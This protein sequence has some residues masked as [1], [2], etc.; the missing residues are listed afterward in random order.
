MSGIA[1]CVVQWAIVGIDPVAA[2]PA[3]V[4]GPA[5]T[6]VPGRCT[7]YEPSLKANA[8]PGGWDVALMSTYIW[9]ESKCDPT[10]RSPT[11]DTGL[12]QINDIN[13][14]YLRAALG[15]WV[16]RWS[17]TEPDVNIRSAATLCTFWQARGQSC[18]F[19]WKLDTKSPPTN[20]VSPTA[21]SPPAASPALSSRAPTSAP[22]PAAAAPAV[23]PVAG[24]CTQFEALLASNAPP[25]G[26]DV[27]KMSQL[28]WRNSRCDPTKRWP[29]SAGLFRV[30]TVN[31][32][33]LASALHQK[34][35]GTTLL[36][37]TTNTRAAA[38]LCAQWRQAGKSCYAP[39]SA[40]G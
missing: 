39:W 32:S 31:A 12:L 21:T 3:P 17:L 38:A 1:V 34:V 11:F 7:Q 9:R 40:S 29:T 37:P 28:M 22:A 15:E 24:R 10:V 18:Y 8:P 23:A 27:K 6:S 20:P 25:G 5:G 19:P 4:P 14:P 2:D 13:H 26:W 30:S 36:D 33:Y 16:G 35:D